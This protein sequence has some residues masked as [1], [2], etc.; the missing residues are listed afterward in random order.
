MSSQKAPALIAQL[1]AAPGAFS[2][3]Q[4]VDILEQAAGVHGTAR[5]GQGSDP[6]AEAVTLTA[7][8]EFAFRPVPIERLDLLPD[9]RWR[10]TTNFFGLAGPD[11]P[12]PE[13]YVELVRAQALARVPTATADFLAIFQ[14]RLLALVYRA[15]NALRC[16]GPFSRPGAGPLAPALRSLAGLPDSAGSAE[17]EQML[18]SNLPLAAQQRRSLAG[19]AGMLRRQ[20][21]VRV[22]ARE[23]VGRWLD[24]PD[25]LHSVL[26]AQGRNDLLGQGAVLG[27]R[28]WRADGAVRVFFARQAGPDFLALLPGGARHAELMRLCAWY[29]GPDIACHVHLSLR[30]DAVLDPVLGPDALLGRTTWLGAA[31]HGAKR[32]VTFTVND[33]HVHPPGDIA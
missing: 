33:G 31:A 24:L 7:A 23:W 14:H 25:T 19:L 27:T 29:L 17:L 22:R 2:F 11:G 3:V 30:P 21:G 26:G 28:C 5:L 10:L 13:S 32:S 20:F 18:L 16:A 4:A 9:R 6:Q 1:L 15:E 8:F 12:L